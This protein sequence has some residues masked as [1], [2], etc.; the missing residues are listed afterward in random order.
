MTLFVSDAHLGRGSR[1]AS[2]EAERALVDM[3]RAH[4]AEIVNDGGTLVLVG[5]V[6]DQWIEYKHLAPKEGVRLL[7]LLAEWGDAGA[8]MHYVVGNRDPWHVDLFERELGVCLRHQAWRTE[9]E[10]WDTYID[11]GDGVRPP[12]R[13]FSRLF[14]RLQPLVRHATTARLYRMCLPGDTGYGLARWVS[15]RFG[16]DGTPDP[17]AARRVDAAAADV[18]RETGA[19]LVVMGHSHTPVLDASG[20]GTYLNLGYWYGART[21]GRLDAEGP[22]LLRWTASGAVPLRHGSAPALAIP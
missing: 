8:D 18:L 22:A 4:E 21:F 6:F 2:R 10:G 13:A 12:D 17:D 14:S 1:E 19:D 20:A 11:H 9:M 15:R 16:T 3:L 7:G 5:D